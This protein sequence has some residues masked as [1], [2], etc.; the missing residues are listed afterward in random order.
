MYFHIIRAN[1]LV[2]LK[3]I[4]TFPNNNISFRNY[5]EL[6]GL[7]LGVVSSNNRSC[8]FESE[9]VVSVWFLAAA[10]V[11]PLPGN[12]GSCPCYKRGKNEVIL[13]ESNRKLNSFF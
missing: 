6:A 10:S 8:K 12:L 11:L 7:V 2:V 5:R 4:I 13:E 3:Y 1:E 9:S